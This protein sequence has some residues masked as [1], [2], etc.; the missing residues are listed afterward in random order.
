MAKDKKK[1]KGSKVMK[2]VAQE[3]K[4]SCKALHEAIK[5]KEMAA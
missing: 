2:A 1:R 4:E 5:E 3:L